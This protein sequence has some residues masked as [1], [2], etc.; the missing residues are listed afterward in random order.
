M[1]PPPTG[2]GGGGSRPTSVEGG[3]RNNETRNSTGSVPEFPALPNAIESALPEERAAELPAVAVVGR[4]GPRCL[5]QGTL[6]ASVWSSGGSP[7]CVA[8]RRITHGG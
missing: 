7:S 6:T 4:A 3:P 2:G 1:P 5:W 8:A